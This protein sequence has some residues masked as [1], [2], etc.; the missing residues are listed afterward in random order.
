MIHNVQKK[1]D[2]GPSGLT[3]YVFFVEKIPTSTSTIY[4]QQAD[5]FSIVAACWRADQKAQL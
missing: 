5:L 1:S 2:R 4:N 3:V